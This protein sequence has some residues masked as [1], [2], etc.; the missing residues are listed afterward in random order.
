MVK[1]RYLQRIGMDVSFLFFCFCRLIYS[2]CF[3]SA[4]YK[5]S[6][7][8]LCEGVNDVLVSAAPNV[9]QATSNEVRSTLKK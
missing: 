9:H 4:Q 5:P 3:M 6:R 8:W 1:N 2:S 7:Y